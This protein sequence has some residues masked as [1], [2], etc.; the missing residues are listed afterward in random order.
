[1]EVGQIKN[2][3]PE[4]E[5]CYN[6]ID[7]D[8]VINVKVESVD[9]NDKQVC[10]ISYENVKRENDLHT[11]LII[12]DEKLDKTVLGEQ[13][14]SCDICKK[15]YALQSSLVRHQRIHSGEKPFSCD[16]CNKTFTQQFTLSAHKRIH[17]GENLFS[18]DIS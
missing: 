4:N 15:T 10:T 3:I 12:K 1:M 6:N 7:S 9:E 14:F 17:S 8:C 5:E 16:I 13:S 18:C 11:E 2:E